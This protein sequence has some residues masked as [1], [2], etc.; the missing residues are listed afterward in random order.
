MSKHLIFKKSFI[1]ARLWCH[2]GRTPE[3]LT[4]RT[5]SRLLAS[6]VLQLILSPPPSQ[7]PSP[8]PPE[9]VATLKQGPMYR[10]SLYY[11]LL[12]VLLARP[13]SCFRG[14][15]K[16]NFASIRFLNLLL[17]KLLIYLETPI[18]LLLLHYDTLKISTA[19][20]RESHPDTGHFS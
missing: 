15:L 17:S 9:C 1:Y 14:I 16:L 8:P 5:H 11:P 20:N 7:R 12:S 2:V 19:E 4:S 3:T 10:C 13:L 6:R 18:R